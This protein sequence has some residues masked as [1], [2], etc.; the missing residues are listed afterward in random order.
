MGGGVALISLFPQEAR[1]ENLMALRCSVS[2]RAMLNHG[3]HCNK[4]NDAAI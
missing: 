1:L 3:C 2:W 4:S